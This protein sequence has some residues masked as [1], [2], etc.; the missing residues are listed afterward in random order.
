[1][2]SNHGDEPNETR[3]HPT[4]QHEDAIER[5]EDVSPG[6]VTRARHEHE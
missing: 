2:L 1:M 5:Q 4:Q 3:A 6:C